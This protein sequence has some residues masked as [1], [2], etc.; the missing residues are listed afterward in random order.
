MQLSRGK[1]RLRFLSPL[2]G[3]S[4]GSCVLL[5]LDTILAPWAALFWI[6]S[7]VLVCAAVYQGKNQVFSYRFRLI[8]ALL[9]VGLAFA[10]HWAQGWQLVLAQTLV[11]L[12]GIKL[13]E[14]RTQRDAFQFCGLGVLGL[15]VA[16]LFRFDL[17]LGIM[18]LVFFFLGLVLIL[19]Q[20][21]LDHTPESSGPGTLGWGFSLKL[22]L[23]AFV[24]TS[25]TMVIGLLIFFAFPR[26]I[27][28]M[29][30]L[31]PG[32]EASRTGFSPEMSPQSVGEIVSSNRIAFRARIEDPVNP[33]R[34]YWRGAVL[35][36]TDGE[37]WKPGSPQD[38]Q[39]EPVMDPGQDQGVVR[40]TITLN[41]GKTEYLFGLYFPGRVQ[42]V[43]PVYYNPDGSI[44][45]EEQVET[46]IRYRVI[47]GRKHSGQL[48]SRESSAALQVPDGLNQEVINLA[49]IFESED[50]DP[51]E[52]A[53]EIMFYFRA[54]GFEYSL[55]APE[56][57]Q[58]GQ[59]LADFLLRT[60]TGYCELYASAA[61]ILMRLNHI[62][63]RLV[64]GFSGGEFNPVG[65]YWVV[66]DSMAHAWVEAWF[67]DRGWVLL[68]P[69]R[70]LGE[71]V[72]D[73][74]GAERTVAQE[75]A[76]PEQIM[77][78]GLRLVDWL[79]WQWT[80]AIIDLT[81]AKQVRIWRSLGSGIQD[82]WSEL[83]V[84]EIQMP[85]D[86]AR[87]KALW[88]LLAAV[89]ILSGLLGLLLYFRVG[90][91]DHE[92]RLRQRAWK[93]LARKTPGRHDLQTPGREQQVWDWWESSHPERARELKSLY[94]AQRYGP[95][96]DLDQD[97]RLKLLLSGR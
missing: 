59:S 80:N 5:A 22:G 23:F 37:S 63:S 74:A 1:D 47:S 48:T 95:A 53:Q 31:G 30:D 57:F 26:N 55:S 3:I 24:L 87:G 20:H 51:W 82:T 33:D 73:A 96:P 35:W 79:R 69:T 2:L 91:R 97:R 75:S 71:A 39:P 72:P 67:A 29:L 27:N 86:M 76:S 7:C 21:I 6:A 28:P 68:D 42:D 89:L 43:S 85:R 64:V 83:S 19:W 81:L 65:E 38:Y 41:P 11:L 49:K 93:K 52:T 45:M 12:L 4:A 8:T 58:Q 9:L 32:M 25:L 90:G 14:L 40:Q 13:M 62:P 94:Y 88:S 84:P 78:P 18:I 34:L 77:T 15:G 60:R 70:M 56:G 16:S 44:K 17:G 46:A 54:Q 36:D 92:Q 66:R 10:V 50:H 61:A